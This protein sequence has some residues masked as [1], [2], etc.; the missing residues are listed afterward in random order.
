MNVY[1]FPGQ[2]LATTISEFW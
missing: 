1:L 2:S